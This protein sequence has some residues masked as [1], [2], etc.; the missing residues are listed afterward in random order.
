MQIG[1]QVSE[2]MYL[3]DTDI[4]VG[5]A[6]GER[7]RTPNAILIDQDR[8]PGGLPNGKIKKSAGVTLAHEIGHW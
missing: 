7:D 2:M 3:L 4:C 8:L 6:I 1:R 5:I